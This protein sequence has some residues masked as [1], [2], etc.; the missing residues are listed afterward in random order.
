MRAVEP[1]GV[2]EPTMDG[3]PE[4]ASDEPRLIAQTQAGDLNAFNELVRRY[5]TLAFNVAARIVGDREIAADV[6]QD[7]FLS[8]WEHIGSFRGSSFR[9][10]LL[11]IVTNR[12]YDRLRRMKVRQAAS[13]EDMLESD[14]GAELPSPTEGPEGRALRAELISTIQN[15]ILT[16]PA[17]QRMVLVL[18]DVQGLSYEETAV[19]TGA[20]IGTVK[21]RLSRARDKLRQFLRTQG[22]LLPGRYRQ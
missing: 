15:G 17:E 14:E 11:R 9:A 4:P 20:S 21:S 22:E 5:Q 18:C 10:W 1:D 8:A 6:V 13:I 19:A 3:A 12:C 7:S 16:L 2:A